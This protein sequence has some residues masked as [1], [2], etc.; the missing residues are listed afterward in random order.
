MAQKD[1]Y[2]LLSFICHPGDLATP[3]GDKFISVTVDQYFC[4]IL[5][6]FLVLNQTSTFSSIIGPKYLS[7]VV[8]ITLSPKEV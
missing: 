1:S 8:K 6:N 2:A 7:T 4:L 3:F 5:Y